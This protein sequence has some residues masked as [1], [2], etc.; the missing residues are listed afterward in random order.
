MT[1]KL[2]KPVVATTPVSSYIETPPIVRNRNH[3][4]RTPHRESEV[5]EKLRTQQQFKDELDVNNI[6]AKSN[7]GIAPSFT[8]R[9]VARY[10][11]TSNTP[12]IAE[13]FNIIQEAQEAFLQLPA[14]LRLELD[15]DPVNI[16]QL[17]QDQARR[18]KL[19]KEPP[20]PSQPSPTPP[21]AGQA[22]LKG[23]VPATPQKAPQGQKQPKADNSDQE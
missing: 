23:G 9:A 17:T 8:N 11:D 15:N 14:A 19:L 12:D 2:T 7:R 22:P 5:P 10:M 18:F 6:V 21:G 4:M 13:A 20:T 1:T 16:T 3:R